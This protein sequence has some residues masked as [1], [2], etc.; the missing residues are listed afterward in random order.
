MKHFLPLLTVLLLLV[1]L[2][3]L[4]YGGPEYQDLGRAVLALL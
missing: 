3:G 4:C 1:L 2:A